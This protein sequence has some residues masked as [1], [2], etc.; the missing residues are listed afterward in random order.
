MKLI[1]TLFLSA[2]FGLSAVGQT[3]ITN[4]GFESWGNTVPAGDTHEEPT[5]WYS[6]QSGSSIAALGS[7]T[8]FKDATVF[9]SGSYSARLETIA[10]P[11]ST[12]INGSVTTG[13]VNAPSFTKS[14]GKAAVANFPLFFIIQCSRE[15]GYNIKGNYSK[16][17]PYLNLHDGGFTEHAPSEMSLVNDE[18]AMMLNKLLDATDLDAQKSVEMNA[19]MR[20]R[21]IDWY[22]AYLQQHTQH[23]G[24][25]RSL[26]VLRA[27]LH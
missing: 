17:T 26:S 7:Q 11:V 10:G 25:I 13:V 12:V 8:C 22:V 24:N 21:L 1:S 16:E 27:I 14:D 3:T 15:L 20:L 19:D 18:D 5:N 2:A 23:M 9:H 6:N 4:G